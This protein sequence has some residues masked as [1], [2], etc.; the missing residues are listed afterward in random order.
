MT[1][2]RTVIQIGA[3][4]KQA[5][6]VFAGLKDD[7]NEL[8]D[9]GERAGL[10]FSRAA[11][12]MGDMPG[13][14]GAAAGFMTGPA[15]LVAGAGALGAAVFKAADAAAEAA[16]EVGTLAEL[17][18][19]STEE[20]S[21]LASVFGK[22]GVEGKDLSDIMLQTAGVLADDADLAEQLGVNLS[23]GATSATVFQQ[24]VDAWRLTDE[25]ERG[26]LGAKLFGEEG[27]RQM[28]TVIKRVD[29]LGD[30]MDNVDESVVFSDADVSQAIEYENTMADLSEEMKGLAISVGQ[31][32]IPALSQLFEVLNTATS[33]PG[34]PKTEEIAEFEAE[35][36]RSVNR[37]ETI[38]A[39]TRAYWKATFKGYRAELV[40]TESLLSGVKTETE[41]AAEAARDYAEDV[42]S[43]DDAF[44]AISD[45]LSRE[46]MIVD[47]AGQF[48][49]LREKAEDAWIKTAEGA[50]DAKEAQEAYEQELR[51]TQR[52]I[53][54][55]GKEIGL[56]PSTV[57]TLIEVS[58]NGSIA[59]VEERIQNLI[60]NRELQI[61]VRER[62]LPGQN[63]PSDPNTPWSI[64]PPGTVVN[65]TMHGQAS[66]REMANA[67]A[68]W[69]ANG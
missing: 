25:L 38:E 10:S 26:V 30:A 27:V 49:T 54:G 53:V 55:I 69:T 5:A 21:K 34:L 14:L 51:N 17:T 36:Q 57:E 47:L 33:I 68:Q 4:G 39:A 24:A 40:Q 29:D 18:S 48:D 15:G 19:T 2:L 16:V 63:G 13:P 23:D 31:T 45:R 66:S 12:A 64:P 44:K 42:K 59:D 65:V 58:D 35:I 8:D 61:L 52:E 20:A 32:A 9:A 50:D 3:D 37:F 11:D 6:R 43:I 41:L 60:R 67:V 46:Q 62:D 7:A 28:S 1:K 22:A 56:L